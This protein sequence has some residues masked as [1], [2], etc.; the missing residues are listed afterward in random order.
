M[1]SEIDETSTQSSSYKNPLPVVEETMSESVGQP[2]EV[3]FSYAHEDEGLRDEL[4]K[5]LKL[6]ERQGVISAWH[7][8]EI[9]AGDE[10][11]QEIE[12]RLKAADIILLLISADFLASDFCWGVELKQAM[13]RHE[14]GEARVIPII[15]REVDWQGASFGKLQ[16]LPKN[17]EPVTNWS[18]QDQAFADVARGIRRSLQIYG[19]N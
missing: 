12:Q 10:W 8:R 2:P 14:A 17:A 3:F 13:Q 19:S 18:N 1:G 11:R 15:L 5:H 7:D 9:G 4:A 16:A 6:L